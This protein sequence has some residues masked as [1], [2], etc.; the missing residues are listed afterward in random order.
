[1]VRYG[2]RAVC[3]APR[4]RALP[5]YAPTALAIPGRAGGSS[6]TV[7]H[8]AAATTVTGDA[9]DLIGRNNGYYREGALDNRWARI[10]SWPDYGQAIAA[11][12]WAG[13]LAAH[14]GKNSIAILDVGCGIGHFPRQ[15]QS[16]VLFP[17][18][19]AI[20]YDTLDVS[21]YSLNEHKSRLR[22]PFKARNSFN[23]AIQDFRPE[24]PTGTYEVIWC[25]HSLYTVPR[26]RLPQVIATLTSLLAADGRCFIYLPGKH[27]AY[28]QLLDLYLEERGIEGQRYLTA[29]E[30]LAELAASGSKTA[31]SARCDLDHWI[32]AT[33]PDTLAAY[34]NQACFRADPLTFDGWQQNETFRGYLET[35]FDHRRGAW[36]FRQELTLISFARQ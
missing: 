24:P 21:Q 32:D 6:V 1:M 35:A 14:R 34:L 3:R 9:S 33:E 27:S 18:D 30:V 20:D 12:D 5:A 10:A 25:M 4:S 36:R 17:A 15:L 26:D 2:D 31:A 8:N 13:L 28:M 29:E 19:L 22:L 23:S 11:Y 7:T 16:Q